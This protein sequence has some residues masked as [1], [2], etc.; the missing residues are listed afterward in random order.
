MP[1]IFSYPLISII[2]PDSVWVPFI[3]DFDLTQEIFKKTTWGDLFRVIIIP[4]YVMVVSNLVNMHS[5]YNGL[6]SGLSIVLVLTLIVKSWIDGILEAIIP[7]AAFLGAMVALWFFNY[8]PA[9]AFEG[10]IGSLLFGS[11]IGCMIVIQ[12]YW[13]FGFFILFPHIINFL[14]WVYWLIMM[15]KDPVNYLLNNEEHE[16]F[17]KIR[18]DNSLKVPNALTVKWIPNF[19]FKLTEKES[20]II[21]YCLTGIFCIIGIFFL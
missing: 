10:N 4:I 17:G 3:G 15:K 21:L 11:L 6:Q 5:G 20:T 2:N 14:L 8:Y 12:E 9:K 19:Y 1:V 7:S 16:K 13:W 18:N